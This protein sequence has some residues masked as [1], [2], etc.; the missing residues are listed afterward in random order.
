MVSPRAWKLLTLRISEQR[1][2]KS[3]QQH[4]IRLR[5][6]PCEQEG[7]EISFRISYILMPQNGRGVRIFSEGLG[8]AVSNYFHEP[9][10]KVIHWM[11]VNR[12][13]AAIIFLARL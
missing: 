13:E 12:T 9:M 6:H 2:E 8:V 5:M 10:M 4:T 3:A 1:C 7:R 11:L